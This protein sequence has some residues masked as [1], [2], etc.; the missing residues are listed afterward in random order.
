M[1]DRIGQYRDKYLPVK[2]EL[3][4]GN[5]TVRMNGAT[6]LKHLIRWCRARESIVFLLRLCKLGHWDTAHHSLDHL[7]L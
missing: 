7:G 1:H 5:R 3:H 6:K 4:A 2:I